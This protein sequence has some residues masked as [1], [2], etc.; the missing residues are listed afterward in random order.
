MVAH[1]RNIPRHVRFHA[2][3]TG[4]FPV[5]MGGQRVSPASATFLGEIGQT[6]TKLDRLMP[7]D[8]ACRPVRRLCLHHFGFVAFHD[9]SELP[10]G[11]FVRTEEKRPRRPSTANTRAAVELARW[12]ETQRHPDRVGDLHIGQLQTPSPLVLS[13]L[14]FGRRKRS[15]QWWRVGYNSDSGARFTLAARGPFSDNPLSGGPRRDRLTASA[16]A[17]R[18]QSRP[19]HQEQGENSDSR[20]SPRHRAANTPTPP[21]T[22][23]SPIAVGT[24]ALRRRFARGCPIRIARRCHA[25]RLVR[26]RTSNGR[27]LIG[28]D[29]DCRNLIGRDIPTRV[30][31]CQFQQPIQLR[32]CAENHE[33]VGQ[34]ASGREPFRGLFSHR[35]SDNGGQLDRDLGTQRVERS[36]RVQL[37]R[38]QNRGG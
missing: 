2:R 15:E 28:R 26:H 33:C 7:G 35:A 12:N 24:H 5:G 32:S 14:G 34:F 13:R 36:S 11:D 6:S 4:P 38:D 29:L 9:A 30:A 27:D 21:A 3:S 25:C 19:G 8:A 23:M 31:F 17:T 10:F 18:T 22:E 16:V 37:M 1:R 20:D